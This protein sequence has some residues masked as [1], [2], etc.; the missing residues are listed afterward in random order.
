[1]DA[2]FINSIKNYYGENNVNLDLNTEK[3]SVYTNERYIT[4]KYTYLNFIIKAKNKNRYI[5]ISILNKL[6]W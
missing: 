4:V 6:V 2:N 3:F 1:M 5:K